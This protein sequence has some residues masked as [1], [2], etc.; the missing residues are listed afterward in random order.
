VDQG[1]HVP[2]TRVIDGARPG[3]WSEIRGAPLSTWIGGAAIFCLFVALRWG[4]YDAPLIRDEG[5]YSY[6][7]QLLQRGLAPYE[8]SFLQKPPMAI[9]SYALASLL[10]VF[11]APRL[12]AYGSAAAASIL[13]GLIARREFGPGYALPA[14]AVVTPLLL[15]P[16]L[17]AFT[18]CTE[19]F[20]LAPLMGMVA[21]Y[22][23]SRGRPSR[24]S[25]WALGGFL[26][27][28]AVC[29]KYTVL[30]IIG[31]V[32]LAWTIEQARSK[33]NMSE[34]W[35]RYAGG[36]LGWAFGLAA[37][38]GYFLLHD[39][40]RHLWE[41]TVAFNRAYVGSTTF[42]FHHLWEMLLDFF[43]VWPLLFVLP[44]LGL[45]RPPPRAWFW[46]VMFLA[47]L[48]A[49]GGSAYGQYYIVLMPFWALLIS[50]AIGRSSLWL[51]ARCLWPEARLRGLLTTGLV[52]L[53]CMPDLPLTA[54]GRPAFTAKEFNPVSPFPESALV[55]RRV[56]AL[57]SPEDYVFIAG[58]EPQILALAHR[59]SP[60]RFV[61]IY[62]L[63]MPTI[64]AG[65]YQREAIG[66]LDTHLPKLIVVATSNTSW[67]R[68]HGTPAVFDDYLK[69]ILDA[70]YE[71]LGGYVLGEH[72]GLWREPL[73][74]ADFYKCSL[75]LYQLKH[76]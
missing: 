51:K 2:V 62:P 14:M 58:S 1:L 31:V 66:D 71:R 76:A 57:T 49:T 30:P 24:P 8:H 47:A 27:A 59:M 7:A 26:S 17:A 54:G 50:V 37:A 12:L 38:L 28:V 11:W 13:L 52:L 6:A 36:V 29:H 65:Q 44:L 21:T 33:G 46:W 25:A 74:D 53:L 75:I 22:V 15:L 4:V 68:Q 35:R 43:R 45:F 32:W 61:I 73:P 41:C 20:L 63:M 19:M 34:L 55:A 3:I 16:G 40:G 64:L 18:A 10:K 23:L 56:A 5:E 60:T 39:H 67:L 9:Y 42:G 48:A 72:S 70:K 69:G